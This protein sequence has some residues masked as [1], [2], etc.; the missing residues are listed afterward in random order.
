MSDADDLDVGNTIVPTCRQIL[1]SERE[2]LF[3]SRG[4]RRLESLFFGLEDHI[5]IEAV[6]GKVQLDRAQRSF[7]DVTNRAFDDSNPV[8]NEVLAGQDSKSRQFDVVP[9]RGIIFDVIQRIGSGGGWL[10]NRP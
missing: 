8:S 9:K 7:A 2:T 6:E 4:Q 5:A 1:E 3:L 10:G